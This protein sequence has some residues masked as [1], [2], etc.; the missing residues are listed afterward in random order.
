MKLNINSDYSDLVK[1][2]GWKHSAS[3]EYMEVKYEFDNGRCGGQLYDLETEVDDNGYVKLH[4]GRQNGVTL[5]SKYTAAAFRLDV[6]E[7]LVEKDE[8]RGDLMLRLGIRNGRSVHHI[9][10]QRVGNTNYQRFYFSG[11]EPGCYQSPCISG[12][13]WNLNRDFELIGRLK[14]FFEELSDFMHDNDRWTIGSNEI[15]VMLAY[16][17]FNKD[18]RTKKDKEE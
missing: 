15:S 8:E 2:N 1:I 4:Y 10:L 16:K 5:Y 6:L 17:H 13:G 18:T 12:P 9:E 14:P 3:K 7:I 11:C